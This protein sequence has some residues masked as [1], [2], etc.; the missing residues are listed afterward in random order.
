M[1]DVYA[2][3]YRRRMKLVSIS[4]LYGSKELDHGDKYVGSCSFEVK[5]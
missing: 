4:K 3:E 1:K 5:F 2:T